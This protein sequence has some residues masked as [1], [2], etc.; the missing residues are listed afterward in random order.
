MVR[1]ALAVSRSQLCSARRPSL[2]ARSR[3]ASTR[4]LCTASH[5]TA[6]TLSRDRGGRGASARASSSAMRRRVTSHADR[7]DV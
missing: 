1:G 2:R 3:P 7:V 6:R 4:V 5:E